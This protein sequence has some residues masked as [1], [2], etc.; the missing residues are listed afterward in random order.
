MIYVLLCRAHLL[1]T[2]LQITRHVLGK[3]S[4]PTGESSVSQQ[5]AGRIGSDLVKTVFVLWMNASLSV[6]V[7]TSL[8]D[9][10]LH[11]LGSLTHWP[12]VIDQW[13]VS[14]VA[15][16]VAE[17]FIPANL[18]PAGILMCNLCSTRCHCVSYVIIMIGNTLQRILDCSTP[19][20]DNKDTRLISPGRW[21]C[22]T[23]TRHASM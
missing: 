19:L 6:S 22:C 23:F 13:K 14:Y 12:A 16:V 1:S 15:L 5:L 10:V 2:L 18:L 8:W 17:H 7:S 4:P 3:T 21:I 20:C 9:D 11:L